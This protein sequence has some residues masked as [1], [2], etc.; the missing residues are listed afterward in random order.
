[1]RMLYQE[2]K[3]QA[4]QE[5]D[6]IIRAKLSSI[7]VNDFNALDIIINGL[8]STYTLYQIYKVYHQTFEV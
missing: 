6:D 2:L 7:A 1:M 4:W 8:R 5:G 3:E